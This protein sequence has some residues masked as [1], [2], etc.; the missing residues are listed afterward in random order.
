MR[1]GFFFVIPRND[2]AD[3]SGLAS[4][5]QI[6]FLLSPSQNSAEFPK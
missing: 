1:L 5:P 6:V 2:G 3:I 4:F